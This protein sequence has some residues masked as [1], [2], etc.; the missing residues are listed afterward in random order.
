MGKKFFTELSRRLYIDGI[1][2]SAIEDNRLEIA[3]RPMLSQRHGCR[4]SRSFVGCGLV[5]RPPVR[6]NYRR[7]R[8]A[9]SFPAARA[10]PT[11]P[12]VSAAGA[13]RRTACAPE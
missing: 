12:T 2:S 8:F 11:L 7:G 4:C 3:V 1:E 10:V 9:I 6:R 5:L 13:T